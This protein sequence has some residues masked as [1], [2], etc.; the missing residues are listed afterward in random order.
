AEP[1]S[2]RRRWPVPARRPGPMPP[3]WAPHASP[4]VMLAAVDVGL[5]LPQMTS[6]LDRTRVRAWCAAIDD[7]PFSSISAG[8][9]ITFDNLDG[10]TV[11][12]VAAGLTQRVRVLLNV[13][14]APW[15]R[16]AMLVKQVASMDVV[17]GGRVE[18]AVG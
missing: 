10:F 14:V 7:G 12:A 16:P 13:V 4:H 2:G 1:S 5:A 9:R 6:G 3:A 17:S 18:L 8:E 15:H 11:C